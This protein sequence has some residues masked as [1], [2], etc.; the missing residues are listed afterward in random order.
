[1]FFTIIYMYG[2][3]RTWAKKLFLVASC[4][5]TYV[6]NYNTQAKTFSSCCLRTYLRGQRRAT[7]QTVRYSMHARTLVASCVPNPRNE[8]N[9]TTTTL[10]QDRSPT[11]L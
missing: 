11:L 10:K 9:E 4:V 7:K 1:M 2:Q 5:R 3:L 8:M 6:D